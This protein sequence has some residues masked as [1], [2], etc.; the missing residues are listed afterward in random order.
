MKKIIILSI[1]CLVLSPAFAQIKVASNNYVGIR[2]TAPANYL[3]I[4]SPW[5]RS[6]YSTKNPLIISHWGTDP[7]LCSTSAI[8]FYNTA[9]TGFIDIQCKTLYENSDATAKENIT[10]LSSGKN[11]TSAETNIDKIKKLNGVNYTWKEDKQKKLQAGF[12]AQEV[13]KVIPE[14]VIT[15][16][17]T[18]IKS[19]AY[20]A[21]IPYLVEAIKEQ[22]AEIEALKKQLNK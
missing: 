19:M 9:T 2:T 5:T 10:S 16:D 4:N 7:R 14:A 8:V 21:I 1:L 17:S 11:K 20:D 22:Q 6:Y 12:L 18:Q 13:E 3:D 15:A